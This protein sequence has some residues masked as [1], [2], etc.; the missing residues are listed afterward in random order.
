MAG[1]TFSFLYLPADA[2]T[3]EALARALHGLGLAVRRA[4]AE[5]A[6]HGE[7]TGSIFVG[8]A[9]VAEFA[10]ISAGEAEALVAALGDVP[11]AEVHGYAM[12]NREGDW[13][14]LRRVAVRVAD[15]FGG[16]VLATRDQE[17]IAG[18]VTVEHRD[19]A[20]FFGPMLAD[21]AY[22]RAHGHLV[23]PVIRTFVPARAIAAACVRK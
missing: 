8:V 17:A 15:R 11:S 3:L 22:V 12:A 13:S 10:A 2:P 7:G 6:L 16:L 9:P 19:L 4:G 18:A 14:A 20:A 21:G 23:P 5:L 1:P